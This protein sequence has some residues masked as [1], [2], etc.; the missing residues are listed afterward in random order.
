MRQN[1][2]AIF[3]ASNIGTATAGAVMWMSGRMD[4]FTQPQEIV[5]LAN[6]ALEW[7]VQHLVNS[8]PVS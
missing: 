2:T 3:H 5:E 1:P 4:V 6:A 8:I 7:Q